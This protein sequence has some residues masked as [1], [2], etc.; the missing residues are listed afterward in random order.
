MAKKSAPFQE[1]IC[2]PIAQIVAPLVLPQILEVVGAVLLPL[3]HE[4]LRHIH[5]TWVINPLERLENTAEDCHH[6]I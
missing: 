4:D 1:A 5:Q 2:I 6:I 3:G